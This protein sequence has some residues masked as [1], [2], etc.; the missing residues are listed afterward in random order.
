VPDGPAKGQ[1]F[2]RFTEQTLQLA[3]RAQAGMN[4]LLG[5]AQ[6]ATPVGFEDLVRML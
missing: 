6:N 2:G 4:R 5:R 3:N 1:P